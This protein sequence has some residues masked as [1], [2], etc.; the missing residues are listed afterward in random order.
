M[1]VPGSPRIPGNNLMLINHSEWVTFYQVGHRMSGGLWS[2]IHLDWS[3]REEGRQFLSWLGL[4]TAT[5]EGQLLMFCHSDNISTASSSLFT[6]W[7]IK[8]FPHKIR[9]F[10][11]FLLFWHL[12]VKTKESDCKVTKVAHFIDFT[13]WL[14][15]R[16][17]PFYPTPIWEWSLAMIEDH[18]EKAGEW[19]QLTFLL[20]STEKSS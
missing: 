10:E 19:K 13:D 7:E 14:C 8:Q 3:V 6:K 5:A 12:G 9:N 17:A 15:S 16:S 4:K 1:E 2:Y 18:K 11:C 20:I